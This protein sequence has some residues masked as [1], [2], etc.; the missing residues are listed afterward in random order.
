MGRGQRKDEDHSLGAAS[1]ST[2]GGEERVRAA[3]PQNGS[4][5]S[6]PLRPTGLS[7][8]VTDPTARL[9]PRL[10]PRPFE[11]WNTGILRILET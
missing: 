3:F 5:F 6:R 1:L 11:Y 2:P 7:K 9:D 4:Q 8:Q 10:S